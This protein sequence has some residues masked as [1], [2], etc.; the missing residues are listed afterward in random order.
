MAEEE[1]IAVDIV[2][3]VEDQANQSPIVVLHDRKLNR[4]LPIWIGDPE[5][6]AI[7]VALNR[8]ATPR[9]LTHKLLVSVIQQMGGKFSRIVVDR[10]KNHT[11]YASIYVK[12]GESDV[13]IDSRPSDAIA[14][15]LEAK[16]PIFVAKSVMDEA[17]QDNPF[18]GIAMRQEKREVKLTEDD[19]ARIR[20]MLE[21]ARAREEHS[22]GAGNG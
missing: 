10:I 16:V 22:S 2:A 18:P 4:L 1:L 15:A 7:A 13:V 17:G 19:V 12:Q 3:L 8:V 21:N 20:K 14:L 9:P 6:R 5:A 11:Y